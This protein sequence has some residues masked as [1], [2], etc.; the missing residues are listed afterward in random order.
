MQNRSP[1]RLRA[2]IS[3]L[4]PIRIAAPASAERMPS[5]SNGRGKRRVITIAQPIRIT[6]P[7]LPNRVALPSRVWPIPT[8]QLAM[9]SAN[10]TPAATMA[11]HVALP[12]P[13]SGWWLRRASSASSGIASASRQN[14]AEIGPL[15]ASRTDHGPSASAML[16]AISAAKCSGFARGG[17]GGAGV[18]APALA[19]GVARPSE[20]YSV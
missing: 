19:G 5:A 7:E 9:S 12:K 4:R 3:R 11:S 10:S 17:W 15:S 2:S 20:N 8:C 16:P 18:I 6:L 1:T 14:P 13:P